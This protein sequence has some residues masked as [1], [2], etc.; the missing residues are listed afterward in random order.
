[1]KKLSSTARSLILICAFLLVMNFLLGFVLIR[2]S[3]RAIREQ[4]ESRMLDVSNT[5]A[6]ML[7]GDVLR[8]LQAE[9]V[10]TPEFRAIYNTLFRFEQNIELAYIYCVRA[11]DDGSFV[12]T[13]DPDPESPGAFGDHIPY[14]EALYNASLGTP[15]VD[16]EAY[17]DQ[18]GR[19]YSAYSP[20]F[21]SNGQVAGIVAVDFTADWYDSQLSNQVKAIVSIS[22]ISIL[23]ASIIIFLVVSRYKKRFDRLFQGMNLISEGIETLVREISLDAEPVEQTEKTTRNT[24][25]IDM[26]NERIFSL[27][28]ELSKQIQWVRSRAY[29]DGLTGLNNRAA[30][31]EH[32]ARLEDEIRGGT[33][34]FAIALFDVNSLKEVNDKYGHKKGDEV[35]RSAA[36]ALQ[37]TFR[38]GKL[39]RIGGDE[40]LVI[41]ENSYA[42]LLEKLASLRGDQGVFSI[43]AGSAVYNHETDR[44]YRTVFNRADTAMYN[45][46]QEYYLTHGDRRRAPLNGYDEP[47]ED[48]TG[49]YSKSA[50]KT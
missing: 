45:D 44:D 30:Y 25:E 16:K 40:F 38:E 28:E 46:K 5:A 11:L 15:G 21:D 24:D 50:E 13:I 27:H 26:L 4:I 47:G 35:I 29:I 31:E 8:T 1:M 9:D 48:K 7:D 10:N 20:A 41:L 36:F 17:V 12:F 14:T 32:V 37:S 33:A 19:F 43:S 2:N 22:G 18:W 39:Y 34:D 6:A 23:V 3:Q 49:E 42:E